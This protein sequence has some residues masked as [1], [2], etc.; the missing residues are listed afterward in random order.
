LFPLRPLDALEPQDL[1]GGA[2]AD[3]RRRM[4]LNWYRA[5]VGAHRLDRKL[6][7]NLAYR[8]LK[9]L[10]SGPPRAVAHHH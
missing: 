5:G 9:R 2:A 7:T 10:V 6:R 4:L 3:L 1:A 8:A